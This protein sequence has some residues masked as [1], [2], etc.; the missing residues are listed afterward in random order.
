MKKNKAKSRKKS[1]TGFVAVVIMVTVI[2]GIVTLKKGSLEAKSE[3]YEKQIAQMK[4]EL[5]KETERTSVIEERK[6][7]VKSKEYIE[8]VAREKL[9]LVHKGEIIF[10]SED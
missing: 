10:E 4:Q 1:R 3:V 8:E 9:G 6:S 2:C 7:Y 5:E